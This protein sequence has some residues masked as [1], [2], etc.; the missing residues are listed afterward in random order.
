MRIEEGVELSDL[1]PEMVHACQIIDL[2]YEEAGYECW[3]TSGKDGMHH[4]RPLEGDARDP[5]Y[6]GKAV[7]FRIHN[8]PAEARLALVDTIRLA[9]G[10]RYVVLWENKGTDLEHL[11]VQAG[12]VLA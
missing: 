9:L 2:I 8:V 7:D 11:H 12:H 3:I 1:Q 10:D 6:L 4:G 5:H